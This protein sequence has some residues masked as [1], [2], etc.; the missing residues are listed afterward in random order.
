MMLIKTTWPPCFQHG[1]KW[2]QEQ[3]NRVIYILAIFQHW[4]EPIYAMSPCQIVHLKLCL[5]EFF[6]EARVFRLQKSNVLVQLG[7]IRFVSVFE[8]ADT[9]LDF[10]VYISI[11]TFQMTYFSIAFT[12]FLFHLNDKIILLLTRLELNTWTSPW[13]SDTNNNTDHFILF[14]LTLQYVSHL[15]PLII[16]LRE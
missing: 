10:V 5:F 2:G 8:H 11:F 15:L 3:N 12:I 4:T 14:F 6:I 13:N 1:I 9:F 7:P 16:N